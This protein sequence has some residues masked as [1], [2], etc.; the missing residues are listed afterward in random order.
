[1]GVIAEDEVVADDDTGLPQVGRLFE[2][3]RRIDNDTVGDDGA[4]VRT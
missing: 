1:V 2:E 3:A 4:D